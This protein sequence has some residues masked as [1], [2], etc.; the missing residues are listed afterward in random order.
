MNLVWPF[1]F[2]VAY[3]NNPQNHNNGFFAI[4]LKRYLVENE[5]ILIKDWTKL[6]SFPTKLHDDV[7]TVSQ[8]SGLQG[9]REDIC[10]PKT[11]VAGHWNLIASPTDSD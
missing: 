6:F 11:I 3:S 8:C 1:K 2:S 10:K 5:I 7:V 9:F 4:F